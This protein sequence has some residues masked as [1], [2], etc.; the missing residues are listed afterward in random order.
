MSCSWHVCPMR[1]A[2]HCYGFWVRP[3]AVAVLV[4]PVRMLSTWLHG[5]A[6]RAPPPRQ[7]AHFAH[8]STA[9]R[10]DGPRYGGKRT[11]TRLPV[12]GCAPVRLHHSPSSRRTVTRGV[13]HRAHPH[14]IQRAIGQRP[15]RSPQGLFAM[16]SFTHGHGRAFAPRLRAER[17]LIKPLSRSKP[18]SP[19]AHTDFVC[20]LPLLRCD[21][22]KP[23]GDFYAIVFTRAAVKIRDLNRHQPPMAKVTVDL[24]ATNRVRFRDQR[25]RCQLTPHVFRTQGFEFESVGGAHFVLVEPTSAPGSPCATC[26]ARPDWRIGHFFKARR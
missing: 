2:P 8:A 19:R 3:P 23:R 10:H 21:H 9:D 13:S 6:L 5:D 16:G 25:R 12:S 18:I 15:P 14:H 11:N 1:S 20:C 4:A 22:P 24:P 26:F 17:M 7:V